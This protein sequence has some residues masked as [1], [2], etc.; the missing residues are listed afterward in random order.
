MNNVEFTHVNSNL[1]DY[2]KLEFIALWIIL[3]FCQLE[4]IMELDNEEGHGT[5]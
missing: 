3:F 2:F 4:K 5:C 1:M